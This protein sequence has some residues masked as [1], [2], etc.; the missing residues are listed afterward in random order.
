MRRNTDQWTRP[1]VLSVILLAIAFFAEAVL[2]QGRL[3]DKGIHKNWDCLKRTDLLR[4]GHGQPIWLTSAELMDRVI[5]RYP[6]ERPGPLGKNSL[7]GSVTI[8]VMIA[9]NG[10]VMCTRGI[11]GHPIAIASAIYSLRKWTFQ[12]YIVKRK[13]R[14]VVGT[15]IISYDFATLH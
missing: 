4:D 11:E 1:M 5:K 2:G 8:E 6:I 15:L 13:S 3:P 14:S 10:K 7:R 9:R 12:P